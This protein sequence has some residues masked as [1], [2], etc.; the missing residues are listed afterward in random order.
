M[1]LVIIGSA[2]IGLLFAAGRTVVVWHGAT[3]PFDWSGG[4][5]IAA[6]GP[7][8]LFVYRGIVQHD[9]ADENALHSGRSLVLH[10]RRDVRRHLAIAQ[11]VPSVT[12]HLVG[13]TGLRA[14]R[15]AIAESD[16]FGCEPK[17]DGVRGLIVFGPG[18]LAL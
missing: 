12:P 16:R 4:L 8:G 7:L 18:E 10:R 15:E 9:R 14:L 13:N 11:V 5:A 2:L 17:V 6:L 3:G 1:K